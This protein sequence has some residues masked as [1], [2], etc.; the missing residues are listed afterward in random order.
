MDAYVTYLTAG[1][2]GG[3]A[4]RSVPGAHRA[5]NGARAAGPTRLRRQINHDIHHELGT[6]ALLASLLSSADDIGPD[7]R[8][9]ARQIVDETHWLSQLFRAFEDS[10][11][12]QAPAGPAAPVP[13]RLDVIAAEV[14]AA[15]GLSTSTRVRVEASE[16][17]ARVDRLA[18]WRALRNLVD[19]A[20]R[21]AGPPGDVKVGVATVGS[22][23]V[24]HVDDSGPGFGAV[25]AGRA[26][27]GLGIAG[28]LAKASGGELAIGSS[29]LGG[30]R[31]LI[32]L[33]AAPLP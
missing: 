20:V 18:F 15:V 17:W 29:V 8:Q 6:I 12:E 11:S 7:S 32:R 4:L 3:G 25:P 19:N 1:S 23:A 33:P 9:R 30:C 26:S 16:A 28:D 10:E 5:R 2:A 27:L 13:T 14:V 31:V 21:A 24:A 22:W